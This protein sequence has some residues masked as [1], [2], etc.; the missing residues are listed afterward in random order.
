MSYAT[1][2]TGEARQSRLVCRRWEHRSRSQRGLVEPVK[3]TARVADQLLV[4]KPQGDLL[5][6][7]FHRVAAV[8]DVPVEKEGRGAESLRLETYKMAAFF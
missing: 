8:D 3:G 7:T 6:G 4:P 2:K 1:G 5:F